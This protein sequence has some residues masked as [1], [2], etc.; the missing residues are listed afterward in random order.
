M[1]VIYIYSICVWYIYILTYILCGFAFIYIFICTI[2]HIILHMFSGISGTVGSLTVS[3]TAPPI[4]SSYNQILIFTDLRFVYDATV[5]TVSLNT[6][7]TGDIVICVWRQ[8]QEGSYTLVGKSSITVITTGQTS[9][10]TVAPKYT[11]FSSPHTFFSSP[12]PFFCSPHPFFC[13][14]H[15]LFSLLR[16][17][18]HSVLWA[19]LRENVLSRT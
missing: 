16:T 18:V 3:G 19:F 12:H 4:V 14:L 13:S 6:V 17:S 10:S 2:H 8:N 11:F 5:T 9:V 7:T 1:C 15:P